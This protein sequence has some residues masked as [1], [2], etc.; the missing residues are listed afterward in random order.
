MAKND[1]S[2]DVVIIGGGVAG[3]VAA[4]ALSRYALRLAMVEKCADVCFGATK[5]SHAIVHCGLPGGAPLKDRAELEGSRIMPDIC[6]QL[7]VSYRRIGKLLVAFDEAE[8]EA[9]GQIR[10]KAA[11]HGVPDLE[12][13]SDPDRLREMEP[14]LSPAVRAAL[15][16]PTTAVVNPW[17][18]VIGL[19]E[20]AVANGCRLMLQTE[21]GDIQTTDEGRF[22]LH[23]NR[24]VILSSWVINAAGLYADKIARLIGDDSFTL[25]LLKQERMILDKQSAS[26]VRHLVRGL[27]NG[28]PTGDFIGPTVDGN[29]MVGCLVEPVDTPER[30]ETTDKGIGGHVIPQYQRL[31]EGLPPALCIRPFAGTIPLAGPE[32]HICSAPGTPR[33]V[34]FVLGASG[35]T[36]SVAMGRHLVE[37]VLPQAGFGSQVKADFDPIRKDIPHFA[38]MTDA[39]RSAAVAADP[40]WGRIVCRCEMVTEGEIKEALRRGATTRDGVKFRTR[41]G[42]G[43]CQSNFCGHKVLSIMSRQ[44][45]VAPSSLTRKGGASYELDNGDPEPGHRR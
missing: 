5:A 24:G 11:Q 9:L 26:S 13:I 21:V 18:L 14:N 1:P 2:F 44:M 34:N 27:S 35:L 20:N 40:A 36:G 45:Q 31:I 6:R 43:R 7:D 32:Y 17:G 8:I 25:K 33:F 42:M 30:A 28:N 16:T 12:L 37:T 4:R 38:Q 39:Q 23:T 19:V 15:F 3:A 29:V 22:A 41:A 10:E